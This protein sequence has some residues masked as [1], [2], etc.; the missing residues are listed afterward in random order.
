[1]RAYVIGNGPSLAYTNLDLLAGKPSFACNSVHLIYGQTIWRPTHYVR[2]EAMALYQDN[3]FWHDSVRT[4]LDMGIPCY[5]SGYYKEFASGYSNYHEIKHCWHHTMN[6][7]HPDAPSEWHMPML[8][9]FGGSLIVAMQLALNLGYDEL[10]LVGCDLNYRDRKP[11]HFVKGYEH[12]AEQ[13][14]RYAN[15]NNLWA[16]VCGINYFAR[17]GLP[18]NVINATIGGDLHLYPRARLEEIV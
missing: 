12:G 3:G 9:Q 14:A 13:P 4:H 7:D 2:A 18:F 17:R 6:Y 5:M 8:C 1:M 11:N 10:V 16:H 15:L